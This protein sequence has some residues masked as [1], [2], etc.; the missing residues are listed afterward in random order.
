MSR[1]RRAKGNP[2]V[3]LFI[4]VVGG[5]IVGVSSCVRA[6][7]GNSNVQVPDRPRAVATS[8]HRAVATQ[9]PSYDRNGDGSVT[10]KDFS[11]Q[12][13]AQ[14]AYNAGNF[15]LDGNDN[16]GRACESLP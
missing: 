11:S 3:A 8:T 16:D 6:I 4:L 12:A 5:F 9:R 2:T 10:C 15:N 1:R 7:T 14:R 13:Q